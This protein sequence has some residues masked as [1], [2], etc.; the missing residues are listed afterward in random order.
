[1]IYGSLRAEFTMVVSKGM[2]HLSFGK[3]VVYISKAIK[4]DN[5]I[6]WRL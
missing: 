6:F 1:M 3:I 2:E 5:Q 4:N